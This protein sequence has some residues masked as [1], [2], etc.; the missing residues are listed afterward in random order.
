MRE[1]KQPYAQRTTDLITVETGKTMNV[2]TTIIMN[3]LIYGVGLGPYNKLSVQ[4]PAVIRCGL[5]NKVV[6]VIG[7]GKGV[8]DYVHLAD[9]TKLYLTVLLRVL[10]EQGGDVPMVN[11]A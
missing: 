2:P 8:W 11:R 3:P 7:E 10:G 6:E 4:I 1:E 9:L 5:K